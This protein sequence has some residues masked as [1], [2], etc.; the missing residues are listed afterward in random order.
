[1]YCAILSMK[2][3]KLWMHACLSSQRFTAYA[4]SDV[5]YSGVSSTDFTFCWRTVFVA[6]SEE[7]I[8]K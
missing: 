2:A 8:F 4:T 6:S 7:Y 5:I 1:M 3:C